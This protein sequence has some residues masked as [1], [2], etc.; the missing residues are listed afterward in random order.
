MAAPRERTGLNVLA[1]WEGAESMMIVWAIAAFVVQVAVKRMI[2]SPARTINA[3]T[4]MSDTT[5]GSL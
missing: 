1:T 4:F 5:G 2:P 3:L